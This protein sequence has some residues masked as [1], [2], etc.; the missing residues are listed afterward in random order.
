MN[1]GGGEFIARA[2][3]INLSH[4]RVVKNFI[5]DYSA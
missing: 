2:D 3:V 4:L 1:L 5:R